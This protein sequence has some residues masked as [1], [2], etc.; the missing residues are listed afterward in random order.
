MPRKLNRSERAWVEKRL[1]A[2]TLEQKIG[3]CMCTWYGPDF[4][5]RRREIL[6]RIEPGTIFISDWEKEGIGKA[7]GQLRSDMDTPPLI[8][9]DM[10]A[11]VP[12]G[13]RFPAAMGCA[14]GSAPGLMR[15][16]GAVT[17][18]EA[19]ALGVHWSFAPCV[20]IPVN[21][22]N[23][24]V[25]DRAWGRD[26]ETVAA[27]TIPLIKGMQRNGRLAATAKHFP[28]AG[29]DDRD[30]HICTAVNSLGMKRWRETFGQVWK[31]V[32]DAGV[33]SIM[34]GHISLP[35][36]NGL[37]RRPWEA[38]PATLDRRLMIDLLREELGFAGV[39]VSDA[40]SMCG[41]ASRVRKGDEEGSYLAA[42]GD[43]CLNDDPVAG[44]ASCMKWLREK[45]LTENRIEDAARRV[46]ELKA[47][48][49]IV[50]EPACPPPSKE[51]RDSAVALG[52][53]LA[54]NAV[55]IQRNDG[56]LPLVLPRGARILTVTLC[57]TD[58]REE[59]RDS[60]LGVIDA[61]LRRRGFSVDNVTTPE[62]SVLHKA[63]REYDAVLINITVGMHSTLGSIRIID[64]MVASLWGAF[65]T[66]G[67]AQVVFTSLASPYHLYEYPHWPNMVLTH[68]RSD[69][70]QR[71]VVKVWLG[72]TAARGKWRFDMPGK[73]ECGLR[74]A[75]C[76]LVV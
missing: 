38:L 61:E 53:K 20:D 34:A 27:Y 32:I 64:R 62:A 7:T 72:E 2:M 22:Q 40:F 44:L 74:N 63:S 5:K 39:I 52:R 65:W 18:Q 9:M 8:A 30:Q 10:E 70:A 50:Q 75:D 26:A 68:G 15:R 25:N 1:N 17:A 19:R 13:V 43:S 71:A 67:T 3:Q 46:L 58:P 49:R 41:F 14:A 59:H 21:P 57:K 36:F 16:R 23:L 4:K 56:T 76:G 69:D 31:A 28:G 45:K 24:E 37:S 47:R 54:E 11:G 35:A 33:Y 29:V 60:K 42:G 55:T 48:L 12:G 73:V 66:G 6:S 51:E